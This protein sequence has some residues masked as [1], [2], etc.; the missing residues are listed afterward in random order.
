MV[1]EG[2][3][4]LCWREGKPAYHQGPW[5]G[6]SGSHQVLFEVHGHGGK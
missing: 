4:E 2:G 3:S 6:L 1:I 5:V